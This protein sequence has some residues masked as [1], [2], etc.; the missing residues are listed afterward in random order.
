MV[1]I[2]DELVSLLSLYH[3]NNFEY[4]V[5]NFNQHSFVYFTDHD[6]YLENTFT[7]LLIHK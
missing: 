3:A 6:D 4:F 7:D 5:Y 1:F 2:P